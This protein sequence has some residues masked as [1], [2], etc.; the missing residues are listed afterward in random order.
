MGYKVAQK[1]FNNWKIL[2]G[3]K[4]RSLTLYRFVSLKFNY[5]EWGRYGYSGVTWLL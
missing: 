5:F 1:T 2:R 3:D 4:V